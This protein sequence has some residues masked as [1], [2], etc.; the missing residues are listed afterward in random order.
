MRALTTTLGL[1]LS[2]ACHADPHSVD[3]AE[4]HSSGQLYQG[5]VMLNQAAGDWQQQSN[6]RA[7]AVGHQAGTAVNVEQRLDSLPPPAAGRDSQ[8]LIEGDAFSRGSGLLGINQGAGLG[9]Q[10]INAVRLQ[11]GVAAQSLDDSALA[12]ATTLSPPS[13]TAESLTGDRTVVTDDR[14]F[15]GSRGVVQ[16]NQSAGVGNQSANGLSIRV[17]ELP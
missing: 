16:L 5:N 15:A 11:Q 3:R 7:I 13:G 6:N 4:L 17:V 14:A 12:Q 1:L 9:N 10:Q 8:A 2:L